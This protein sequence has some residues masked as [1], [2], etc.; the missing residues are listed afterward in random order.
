MIGQAHPLPIPLPPHASLQ[1]SCLHGQDSSIVDSL[2]SN[3]QTTLEWFILNGRPFFT[4]S[5]HPFSIPLAPP[6]R[7]LSLYRTWASLRPPL[8]PSSPA[9]WRPPPLPPP[10]LP[11]L[12]LPQQ[13]LFQARREPTESI[14][15]YAMFNEIVQEGCAEDLELIVSHYVS[16]GVDAGKLASVLPSPLSI[17]P[18]HPLP[19]QVAHS[20]RSSSPFLPLRR[21]TTSG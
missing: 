17:P 3:K 10:L 8:R 19:H 12:S 11:S 7:P 14:D 21:M 18:F 2:N 20:R 5:S 9:P 1:P 13:A 16:H 15:F 6:H 4:V